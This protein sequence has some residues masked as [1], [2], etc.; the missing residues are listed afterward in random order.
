M[1]NKSVSYVTKFFSSN[2]F[3]IE[4]QGD[5]LTGSNLQLDVGAESSAQPTN[6]AKAPEDP[7]MVEKTQEIFLTIQLT[8]GHVLKLLKNPEWLYRNSK[9][10][11]FIAHVLEEEKKQLKTHF[12]QVRLH[13]RLEKLSLVLHDK[14]NFVLRCWLAEF[15]MFQR[16]LSVETREDLRT[17]REE[18]ERF[19]RRGF[20]RQIS[21]DCADA[22]TSQGSVIFGILI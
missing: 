13:L 16:L 5:G 6:R 8:L 2:S 21:K 10:H 22:S 19:K 1:R 14:K 18:Y 15:C 12:R 7:T 9:G 20:D 3:L 4:L 11:A 17:V